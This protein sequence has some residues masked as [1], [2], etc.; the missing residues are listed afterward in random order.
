MELNEK[1]QQLRKQRGLTQEE[2]AEMLYVSRTAISK[3]ESGRGYPSIDSLKAISKL[4]AISIDDLLS[5]EELMSIAETDQKEKT[6]TMRDLI[7][8]ALDCMAAM[9][10]FLP[11]FGERKTQEEMIR[12][13]SM[14]ELSYLA[15][16]MRVAYIATVI[17]IVAIGVLEL[18]SQRIQNRV[19][20]KN[21]VM[22]SLGLNLFGVTIFMASLQPYAGFFLL[23][24]LAVKGIL[25]IKQR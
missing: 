10:F 16:Y 17:L 23:C 19:W 14:M 24:T 18:L 21:R 25:A 11:F 12:S 3:W 6:K 9:M 20:E 7:F 2:L 5:S 15:P 8:G 13:V 1:L 22:I 4:F